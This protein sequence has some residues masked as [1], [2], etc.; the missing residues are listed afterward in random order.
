MD[1]DSEC[2]EFRWS[3]LF[4]ADLVVELKFCSF[5]PFRIFVFDLQINHH[6]LFL[7]SDEPNSNERAVLSYNIVEGL[8]AASRTRPFMGCDTRV[9]F[10]SWNLALMVY[11]N[12][13]LLGLVSMVSFGSS[14][15]LCA[16][17]GADR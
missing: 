4:S 6:S 17:A 9:G 12:F 5:H 14:K 13:D 11:S 1:E 7:N 15:S 10:R 2:G 3:C 16:P 8:N